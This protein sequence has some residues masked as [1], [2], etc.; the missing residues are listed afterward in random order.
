MF[1]EKYIC[2]SQD[3]RIAVFIE[4]ANKTF[5]IPCPTVLNVNFEFAFNN[6]SLDIHYSMQL[7]K[8]LR[9]KCDSFLS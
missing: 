4:L 7:S 6:W 1:C 9:P 8:I 3:E 5:P 2:K